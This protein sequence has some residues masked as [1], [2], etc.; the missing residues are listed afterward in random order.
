MTQPVLPSMREQGSDTDVNILSLAG[1]RTMALTAPAYSAAAAGVS[2]FTESLDLAEGRH[3]IRA[4]AVGPGEV[5]TPILDERLKRPS[6]AARASTL[7]PEDLAQ[8]LRFLATLP[9][10]ATAEQFTLFAKQQPDWSD[11]VG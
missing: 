5:V 3:G 10:R 4:R 9:Q 11:E 1:Y 8:T 7:E 6:A 2:S